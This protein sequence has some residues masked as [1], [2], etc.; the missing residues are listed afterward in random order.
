MDI[1]K[2][3]DLITP[4]T[5]AQDGIL[6]RIL[7]SDF[8]VDWALLPLSTRSS[9]LQ[10]IQSSQGKILLQNALV[11]GKNPSGGLSMQHVSCTLLDTHPGGGGNWVSYILPM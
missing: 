11:M 9:R 10:G 3:S 1:C 2:K 7:T 8:W 4:A 6:V 5:T